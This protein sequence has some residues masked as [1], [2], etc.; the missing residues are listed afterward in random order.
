MSVFI[1]I[2]PGTRGALCSLDPEQGWIDFHDTPAS[3]NLYTSINHVSLWIQSQMVRVL[4][5]TIEDVHSLGGMSAKSNFQFGRNLAFIETL[6][7]LWYKDVEYVQ[8]KVWQKGCGI[9][10]NYPLLASTTEKAKYRKRW[11]GMFAKQ[12]YPNAD[13]YGPRGGLLDGR[14]DALMI[15]HYS[16]LKYKETNSL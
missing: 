4:N 12:L 9:E 14:A 15:A 11:I 6:A 10:F 3:Y 5:L 7:H 2:D 1:G 16:Y 8:P 13:I